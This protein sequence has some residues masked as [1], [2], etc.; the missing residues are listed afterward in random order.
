MLVLFFDVA[1]PV[2]ALGGLQLFP[3]GQATEERGVAGEG[4]KVVVE[5][6]LGGGPAP[7]DDLELGPD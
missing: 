4:G 2:D 6:E 7:A 5:V 1:V 3:V